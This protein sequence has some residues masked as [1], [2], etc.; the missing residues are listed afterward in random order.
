M[1][2]FSDSTSGILFTC[3][4]SILSLLIVA[5]FLRL[6]KSRPL[7]KLLIIL[8]ITFIFS[9]VVG[10]L[11]SSVLIRVTQMSIIAPK[12]Q[13]VLDKVCGPGKFIATEG[14]FYQASG[15]RWRSSN[16]SAQCGDYQEGWACSCS[17]K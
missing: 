16:N 14:E 15:F 17:S 9:C 3:G 10:V 4:F 11:I 8:L 7:S 6:G 5:L 13:E 2:W 1:E 12:V